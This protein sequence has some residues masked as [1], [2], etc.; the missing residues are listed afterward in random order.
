M[1][2]TFVQLKGSAAIVSE[3]HTQGRKTE[4]RPRQ[5]NQSGIETNDEPFVDDGAYSGGEDN[6]QRPLPRCWVITRPRDGTRGGETCTGWDMRVGIL[7]GRNIVVR[8]AMDRIPSS[9]IWR[10]GT[11][12]FNLPGGR[13]HRGPKYP[14][15]RDSVLQNIRR[16]GTPSSKT[17]N[18][19]G[20]H[21]SKYST[22]WDPAL[23]DTQRPVPREQDARKQLGIS[24]V[25]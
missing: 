5:R 18:G 24:Y 4:E 23:H 17:P 14:T 7:P 3:G 9:K 21:P 19:T 11:P 12:S 16:D 8:N 25:W 22:G 1:L 6:S 10:E 15:G 13:R 20:P 2:R